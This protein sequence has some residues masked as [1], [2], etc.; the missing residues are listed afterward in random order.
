MNLL[1]PTLAIIAGLAWSCM[2]TA[3]QAFSTPEKA[4][5]AFVMALDDTHAAGGHRIQRVDS[6]P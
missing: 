6:W 2:A 5:E 4:V 1:P 3:Q